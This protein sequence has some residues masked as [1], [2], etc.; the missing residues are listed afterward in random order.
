M[1]GLTTAMEAARAGEMGR[2]F[3]VVAE[4]TR[5]LAIQFDDTKQ[6][7]KKSNQDI[8][9]NISEVDKRRGRFA[10]LRVQIFQQQPTYF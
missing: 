5:K 8:Q 9:K 1:L 10:I 6:E 3:S 4:E 2:G 7:I